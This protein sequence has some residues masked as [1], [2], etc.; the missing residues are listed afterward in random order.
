MLKK[1]SNLLIVI[2]LLLL[3]IF[4]LTSCATEKQIDVYILAGGNNV[5]GRITT[6][7]EAVY[8]LWPKYEKY[9][10]KVLSFKI[11]EY[12]TV[13]G[14][15]LI[16]LEDEGFYHIGPEVG[17]ARKLTEKYYA[18]KRSKKMSILSFGVED[19]TM[20]ESTFMPGT[21]YCE[22]LSP[23]YLETK[24]YALECVGSAYRDFIAQI[25]KR[26]EAFVEDGYIV[27]IKAVFWMHGES[28][29]KYPDEYA[30]KIPFLFADMR[31]DL[32]E[33]LGQD[34]STLP[35]LVGELS[36]TSRGADEK[37]VAANEQF[38][39]MQRSFAETIDNVYIIPTAELETCRWDPE[40]NRTVYDKSTEHIIN[41]SL[42]KQLS[43]GTL[44]GECI[45]EN[46]LNK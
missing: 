42:E 31:K 21:D 43:V 26:I 19:S 41:W 35:I 44:V 6:D 38:I 5:A 33:I 23:S 39:Q 25:K 14:P 45:L 46:H 37:N 29:W 15:E 27:N 9:Y 4:S 10:K 34:L 7:A 18:K 40:Q 16:Q 32:G 2:L 28:D 30:E 8:S 3:F 20:A 11:Q 24:N 12:G 36:K 1:L 22:W 17:L 13:W